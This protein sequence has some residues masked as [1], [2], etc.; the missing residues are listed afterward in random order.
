MGQQATKREE[1]MHQL[2]QMNVLP[3]ATGEYV[4]ENDA[5]TLTCMVLEQNKRWTET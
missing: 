5:S 3:A 4:G 1:F 2:A